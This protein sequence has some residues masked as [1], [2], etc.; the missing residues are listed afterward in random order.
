MITFYFNFSTEKLLKVYNAYYLEDED[1]SDNL[2]DDL[3]N[4]Q[5]HLDCKK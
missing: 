5:D 4:H 3:I 1:E 2:G